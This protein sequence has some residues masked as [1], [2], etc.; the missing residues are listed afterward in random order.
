MRSSELLVTRRNDCFAREAQLV[1]NAGG[2]TYIEP[3]NDKY[4]LYSGRFST[5]GKYIA[6]F[7][8]QKKNKE[9]YG[10]GIFDAASGKRLSSRNNI[11]APTERSIA[12]NADDSMI[13]IDEDRNGI[14][15]S[16]IDLAWIALLPTRNLFHTSLQ[17][18]HDNK[19]L[20]SSQLDQINLWDIT[21]GTLLKTHHMPYDVDA[22][23]FVKNDTLLA[24]AQEN[25]IQ[26]II[27]D[28]GEPV[29][30]YYFPVPFNNRK[31]MI[32]SRDGHTMVVLNQGKSH[33]LVDPMRYL[34]Y[35]DEALRA[36]KDAPAKSAK[37][38]RKK[39]K[40]RD[41]FDMQHFCVI[42]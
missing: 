17:F 25:Y 40:L 24:V 23:S 10:F 2:Q 32:T 6:A 29:A 3:V 12:F 28:T 20:I 38:P 26:F 7:W 13:A 39:R 4:H 8:S 1:C 11:F 21:S 14:S 16:G 36:K 9:K 34:Q 33:I 27:P 35:E 5:T 42:Q 41:D 15:L 37:T 22:V 19:R 30:S 18:S 31:P